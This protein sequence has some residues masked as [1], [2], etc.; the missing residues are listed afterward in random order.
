M[1][2]LLFDDVDLVNSDQADTVRISDH[3]ATHIRTILKLEVGQTLRVGRIN[4][5]TGVGEILSV[6]N[7][8]VEV[9]LG[10]LIDEP[11]AASRMELILALPRPKSLKRCLRAAANL[12][13]KSIHLI[14]SQRVDK[15]Y[16]KAPVLNPEILREALLDGLSIARDTV[17][18]VVRLHNLFKPFVQDIAPHLV[19]SRAFVAAPRAVLQS[20]KDKLP[21]AF[22]DENSRRNS[23]APAF[24]PIAIGP[25]GGFSEYEVNLFNENGFESLSLGDRI[26]SVETALPRAE[27]WL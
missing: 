23:T 20:T 6:S 21:P 5:R 19:T 1:N 17:L 16:W 26:Y 11:P 3:R 2:I 15:S 12:G 9:R 10:P 22:R 27:A 7:D 18:P 24:I 25:E 8:V 13:I 14:H 4:G